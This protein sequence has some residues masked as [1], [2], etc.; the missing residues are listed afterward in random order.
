MAGVD[1]F[2]RRYREL[3]A[4]YYRE[5]A[6]SADLSDF[7]ACGWI[8][9]VRCEPALIPIIPDGCADILTCDEGPP[10]VVGPDAVT[11]WV[12]LHDGAI[13]TGLRL[14]P[15]AA[16]AVFGCTALEL[17]GESAEL[18]DLGRDS[19]GLHHSL[20]RL[21]APGARLAQL[22]H[23][24]RGRLER[25]RVRELGVLSACRALSRSPQLG[26][27]SLSARLGWNGRML[28]RKFVA[29]CGYSP[30]HLQRILRVQGV[31]R[32]AQASPVAP[33]LSQ[34]AA[35]LGF[36][37]QAHLNRDFKSIT[38]FAPSAYLAQAN[39]EVGRWLDEPWQHVTK[40][41]AKRCGFV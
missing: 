2:I 10:F 19:I 26:L 20:A 22:E 4:G 36:A 39:A 7:I 14:R 16:Q 24:V 29:A 9:A 27:D 32:A 35:T 12:T 13:I 41:A 8:K 18:S 21:H 17:L 5:F 28:H 1:A 30:K 38:G 25:S 34:I 11:R 33:R 37:D 3:P 6:P 31:L 40:R 15:G 23:W